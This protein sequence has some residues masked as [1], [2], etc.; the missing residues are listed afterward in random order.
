MHPSSL[1]GSRF[2]QTSYKDILGVIREAWFIAVVFNDNSIV[3]M[4]FKSY[5]LKMQTDNI[6]Y[7]HS[8]KID[9]F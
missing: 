6:L 5:F 8:S 9:C 1:S 2:E 3:I 7:I 4:V